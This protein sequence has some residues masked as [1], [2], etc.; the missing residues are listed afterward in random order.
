MY[1]T[2]YLGHV[3]Q[4]SSKASTWAL[5]LLITQLYDPSAEVCELA[6]RTLEEACE[7]PEILNLTVELQPTLDHLGEIGDPLLL[8]FVISDL[9]PCSPVL[10]YTFDSF[11]PDSCPR[12]SDLNICFEVVILSERWMLGSM[13]VLLRLLR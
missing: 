7:S 10:T 8:K 2:E 5:P 4:T 9:K 13:F 6:V 11:L 1:A 3:L 12:L